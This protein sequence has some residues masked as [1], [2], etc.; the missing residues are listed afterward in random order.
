MLGACCRAAWWVSAG[1]CLVVTVIH[2]NMSLRPCSQ[3]GSPE[4]LWRGPEGG[5]GPQGGP[6]EVPEDQNTREVPGLVQDAT[7]TSDA[8]APRWATA[9][10]IP[11]LE[12]GRACGAP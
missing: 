5:S 1:A 2:K 12:G 8:R 4:H 10:T 6:S 9:L 11:A 3:P 7:P